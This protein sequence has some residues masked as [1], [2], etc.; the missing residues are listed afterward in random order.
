[1]SR[2]LARGSGKLFHCYSHLLCNSKIAFLLLLVI[3]WKDGDVDTIGLISE[4][5]S[6]LKMLTPGCLFM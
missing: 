3:S 6:T 2:G 5:Y 4:I 1:M